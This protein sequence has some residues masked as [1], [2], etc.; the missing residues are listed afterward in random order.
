MSKVYVTKDLTRAANEVECHLHNALAARPAPD[1]FDL[2]VCCQHCSPP[3]RCVGL[4]IGKPVQINNAGWETS[5][6]VVCPACAREYAIA[7]SMT[8][9]IN[10]A[11]KAGQHRTKGNQ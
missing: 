10:P 8:P 4:A 5:T 7:V 9:T 3:V 1:H 2:N 6:T 11:A